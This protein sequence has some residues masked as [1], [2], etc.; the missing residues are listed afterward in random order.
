[1]VMASLEHEYLH[2]P[3][4]EHFVGSTTAIS[5]HADTRKAPNWHFSMQFLQDVHFWGSIRPT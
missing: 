3:H 1:M 2:C 5:D 4:P